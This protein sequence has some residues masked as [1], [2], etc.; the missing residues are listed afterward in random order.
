MRRLPPILLLALS[1]LLPG[2]LTQA[3]WHEPREAPQLAWRTQMGQ[4]HDVRGQLRHGSLE[5]KLLIS[6]SSPQLQDTLP[7]LRTYTEAT[8][9]MLELV[10]PERGRG[11]W[12]AQPG[13][14]L[15]EPEGWGFRVYHG[16]YFTGTGVN[17]SVWFHGRLQPDDVCRILPSHEVPTTLREQPPLPMPEYESGLLD[18]CLLAFH[19]HDWLEL[20][21]GKE[22]QNDYERTPLAFVDSHGHMVS[23]NQMRGQMAK[24]TPATARRYLADLSLIARLDGY[25]QGQRNMYVRIPLPVLAQGQR[26]DLNRVLHKVHW[27]RTQVWHGEHTQK[28]AWMDEVAKVR[29]PLDSEVFAYLDA[30]EAPGTTLLPTLAKLALTPVTVAADFLW[31]QSIFF[32]TLYESIKQGQPRGPTGTRGK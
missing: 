19:H 2:C 18:R 23:L 10:P 17:A 16:E 8:P 14:Q 12:Q 13:S 27:Q 30:R 7:Q 24:A 29:L 11:D 31:M 5:N 21:T 3:L 22:W 1:S 28:Q 9:G 25:W 26:L 4:V 15:F 32:K 20:A 6:F